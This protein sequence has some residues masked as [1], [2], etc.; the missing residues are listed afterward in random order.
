MSRKDLLNISVIF[1]VTRSVST[2]SASNADIILMSITGPKYCSCLFSTLLSPSF[3]Q[4]NFVLVVLILIFY[5]VC[6]IP[7]DE[8]VMANSNLPFFF[9]QCPRADVFLEKLVW[10]EPISGIIN[11]IRRCRKY[12]ILGSFYFSL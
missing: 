5:S 8:R 12:K 9:A 11:K 6:S 4:L 7:F 1:L 3:P 2:L 10:K